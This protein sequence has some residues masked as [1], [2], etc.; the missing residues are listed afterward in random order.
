MSF[1][2]L[3]GKLCTKLTCDSNVLPASLSQNYIHVGIPES[4]YDGKKIGGAQLREKLFSEVPKNNS[5]F[6]IFS[7]Q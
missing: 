7:T 5:I 3:L 6:P 1:F 2:C 4:H